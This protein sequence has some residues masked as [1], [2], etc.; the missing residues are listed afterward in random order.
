VML[1]LCSAPVNVMTDL[2]ILVLPLPVLTR[3]Q[4]PRKQKAILLATFALGVFVTIVDVIRIYYLQNAI[5]TQRSMKKQ[6]QIGDSADFA[7][8]ASMALMWSAVEVNTGILCVCI[9]TLRPLFQRIF[10]SVIMDQLQS[11]SMPSNSFDSRP[12]SGPGSIGT[13]DPTGQSNQPPSPSEE[14][15]AIDFITTPEMSRADRANQRP[16]LHG[17]SA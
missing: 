12:R 16:T 2:A 1:Y 13:E 17:L 14:I 9:P 11:K 8:T 10:P 4:L 15:G 5:D 3:L 7:Y 6:E